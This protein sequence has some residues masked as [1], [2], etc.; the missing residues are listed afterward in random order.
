MQASITASLLAGVLESAMDAIITVNPRHHI[1]LFNHAAEKMFGWSRQEVMHQPLDKL[2]P[3]RFHHAHARH[4]EAFGA[5]GTT[6]RAMVDASVLIYGLR[7]NGR[8][9]PIDVSISQVDTPEGK[10]FTAM[11]R[12]IT[13]QQ[14]SQA[15]L[16]LLETSIS[17]LNDMVVITEAEPVGEPGPKIVF[18]NAAFERH[19]GYSR[20]E[21]IGRSPR[22]LQGP[23]TQRPELDRIGAA[24]GTWQPVR[25]E[26]I[27][28]TRSG[29][30]FWVELDIVPVANAQGWFTHW[31]SVQRDISERKLAEQALVDSEQRYTALFAS[32][33][34]PMWVIDRA[35]RKFLT[36][37]QAAIEGYGHSAGEFLAMTLLDIHADAE[38]GRLPYYVADAAQKLQ[39]SCQHCRK[40][41]SLF[42]A[43]I[44]V[45]PI[46]YAGQDALFMVALDMSAQVKAEKEVQ[47]HLFTLQRAA[48]AAQ[49]ITWHLTLEGMMQELAEQARGVI[50]AHQA[51]V[52]LAAE[53]GGGPGA[54]ALSLSSEYAQYRNR[55]LLTHGFGIYARGC[56]GTRP[57]RMAQAALQEHA[58]WCRV[59]SHADRERMLNGWLAVPLTGR[60]GQPIGLLQLSDKYEGEFI[61]QDEYV[62]TE[63]AQLAS[64][65]IVNVRLLQEVSQLNTG[66]EKKVAE[67]T[68]AL[69]RQE[70]L[71]RALAEQAPQV[72]WTLD[73][74]GDAT[75]FNQAWFDLVGGSLQDWSGKQWLAA[76]HPDDLPDTKAN[77]QL[78]QANQHSFS[79][80][81]R[82]LCKDG[83]VHTMA[84]RASP[85][86][87]EQ[88]VAAFWVGI[89][90]DVT[91]IKLIEAA[92][93]LSNQE[94]EAFSYS[95]S[96]DLRAPLST[97]NG[98]GNLLAK[99]LAG[100]GNDKM[101][102]YVSRIQQ[103]VAQMGQLI[104][105]LLSLA[106]VARTQVRNEPVDLSEMACGIVDAWRA[107]QPEREVNVRIENDL[108][109]YGD[110]P[111]LR[112]VME[113]LL[114]N[115][116]KFTARQPQATISVGQQADAAG[117]PVFF[118]R[119][120]G[121]GFDMAQA[122]KLF[123]PFERLHAASEFAGTGVGLATVSRVINRH[124]G[125]L[126]AE[127]APGLGATFFFT[128]HG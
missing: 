14:A 6:A 47:D 96:H 7:A 17:H 5:T 55:P 63:L 32:A 106:Q 109:A 86:R 22:F 112:V 38:R 93:R 78:A 54:H 74:N 59:G 91:E 80:L 57:V 18:V 64:I 84:Y 111:L 70:A 4:L 87:D 89:D 103:G 121:A 90:A 79:G 44:V 36:V 110:K 97:I 41:G 34:V 46:Q 8:E 72:I 53:P 120:N 51:V 105:D 67:R 101:R 119:D 66:L 82:L 123:L 37:N 108:Q 33:P 85:V 99:Q 94:L 20:E 113:N 117:L 124:G 3:G 24:L 50:G 122:E 21:V 26:L 75:Y 118:V 88:G 42:E 52:S 15:Q 116:W 45:R 39:G 65:A 25:S 114:G 68:L 81:R 31:V 13:G 73:P 60:D 35:S 43:D 115:A 102:H 29:Q 107:R 11:V 27:N 58:D 49:A 76:V 30:A 2:I 9:F 95:V 126:W 100:A 77:W 125:K 10:L 62:A 92:L 19:T 48:D 56:H 61:Q 104:E 28:Y 98:F 40:D 128:L 127:A 23:L 83:S 69:A 12:D 16:K 71:F 1:V